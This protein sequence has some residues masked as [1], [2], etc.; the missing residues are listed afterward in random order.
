MA[1]SEKQQDVLRK[2]ALGHVATLGP[3]I[4][5]GKCVPWSVVVGDQ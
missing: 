4:V 5:D 3:S 1:F 2:P